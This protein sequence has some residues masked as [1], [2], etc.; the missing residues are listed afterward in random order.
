MYPDI[1]EYETKDLD[2]LP[3]NVAMLI[4]SYVAS[5]LLMTEDLQR[6]VLL[7]NEFET[8]LSRLDNNIPLVAYSYKNSSGWTY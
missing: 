1:N 3:P 5:Q 8:M 2:W 6:A 7:K 4:P